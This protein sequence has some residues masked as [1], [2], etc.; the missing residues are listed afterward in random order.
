M[1]HP[2]LLARLSA[3]ALLGMAALPL[4][5][6]PP[7]QTD[8][9]KAIDRGNAYLLRNMEGVIK[10]FDWSG[11]PQTKAPLVLYA[12]VSGEA[13]LRHPAVQQLVDRCLQDEIRSTYQASTLALAL[14]ALDPGRYQPAISRCGQFLLDNQCK[15]GQWGYGKAVPLPT[16]TLGAS[17]RRPVT[18]GGAGGGSRAGT[19]T[20]ALTTR[21]RQAIALKPR[22][23]GP[24]R[25]DNS[26]TQYAVLGLR[27]CEEAN[28]RIPPE[29]WTRAL[30]WW[31]RSQRDDGGWN[32]DTGMETSYASMTEGGLGSIAI[33]AHFLNRDWKGEPAAKKGADRV[34]GFDV[35]ENRIPRH[36]GNAYHFYH[37]YALERAGVLTGQDAFG[38]REWYG[39]GA[40]FLVGTQRPDGA[41]KSGS[42][43]DDLVQDTCFA[44][45]FL[46]RATQPL[47]AV[48]TR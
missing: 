45:L 37:L 32:Y 18:T 36:Q 19:G 10:P 4:V 12:L 39:E 27:A 20:A 16:L 13:N 34:N 5:A 41:W 43:F 33:A 25:G 38:G 44:I 21:P 14:E 46:K 7:P 29:T 17:T 1:P 6:A 31:T 35:K 9:N 23:A 48:Y 3:F 28:V 40:A 15:N 47:K 42:D 24:D 26:N 30:D 11:S 8:I 22:G 2:C